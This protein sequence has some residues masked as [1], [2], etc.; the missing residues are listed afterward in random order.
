M[1]RDDFRPGDLVEGN[2]GKRWI[3]GEKKFWSRSGEYVWG[4]PATKGGKQDQ[5]KD[6]GHLDPAGLK[7]VRREHRWGGAGYVCNDCGAIKD[8]GMERESC[9]G[10]GKRGYDLWLYHA[11]AG[12]W[13][14][15]EEVEGADAAANMAALKVGT[16]NVVAVA[17]LP[18]GI[19]LG[20]FTKEYGK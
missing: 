4:W 15:E 14:D 8:T 7:L 18:A 3:V 9:S 1:T 13:L 2:R 5:R 17:I 16:G 19:R 10:T 12:W 6:G 11:G 20:L